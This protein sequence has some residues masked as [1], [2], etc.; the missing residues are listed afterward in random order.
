MWQADGS[1]QPV[2]LRGHDG[3]VS[4]T[5]F[6]PDGTRIVTAAA[7]AGRE[8]PTIAAG[9]GSPAAIGELMLER[10]LI[11]FE[12]ASILLLIAAVGA[13]VLA[14]RRKQEPPIVV[15]EAGSGR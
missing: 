12:A 9:F 5:G 7:H 13:V 1:G 3:S 2:V 6:S 14:A 15:E 11:A 4:A 10:F 8:G